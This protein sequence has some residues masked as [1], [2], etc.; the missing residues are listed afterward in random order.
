LHELTQKPIFY[1]LPLLLS[2]CLAFFAFY[3]IQYKLKEFITDS[4]TTNHL[5]IICFL[6]LLSSPYLIMNLSPPQVNDNGE[7]RI[8]KTKPLFS[9]SE[10]FKYPFAYNAYFE[11][12]F[13]LKKFYSSLDSYFKFKFFHTSS[14]PDLVAIG[15]E[16]WLFSTDPKNSGDFQNKTAF[17]DNEL[18][19][20]QNNLEQTQKFHDAMG[21]HFFVVV[22]PVKSSI[23]PEY[24]PNLFN[25]ATI[26]EKI[27]LF[28]SSMCLTNFLMQKNIRKFITNMIFIGTMM[29]VI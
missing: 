13:G 10:L 29:V 8:L 12:N 6:L 21:I 5:L 15:K 4:F 3:I 11:D 17:T 27:V 16:N 2:L 28:N 25:F 7:N 20:I 14:K 19:V 23:Y 26:S 24:L 22:L 9:F 1:P 18:S